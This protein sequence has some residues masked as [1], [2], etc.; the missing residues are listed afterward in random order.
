L[1]RPRSFIVGVLGVV[2]VMLLVQIITYLVAADAGV[3]R[4]LDG[5]VPPASRCPELLASG[6]WLEALT[7][8]Q[9]EAVEARL[10]SR[11]AKIYLDELDIPA[12]SRV[13]GSNG[14]DVVWLVD[15]KGVCDFQWFVDTAGPFWFR[16]VYS[17]NMGLQF[18]GSA[19]ITYVWLVFI[20]VELHADIGWHA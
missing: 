14:G 13:Y 19:R 6:N 5:L 18:H 9:R 15:L 2:S 7:P 10:R 12:S 1:S 17:T 11:F 20:W 4:T 16:A 3:P 8:A